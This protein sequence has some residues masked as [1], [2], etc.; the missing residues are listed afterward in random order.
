M[1]NQKV[2]QENP[3]PVIDEGWW[4][5]VLAEESRVFPRS[6]GNYRSEGNNGAKPAQNRGAHEAKQ[7][8]PSLSSAVK[9][10]VAD[11]KRLKDLYMQDQI[12][13]LV[14][15]GFN[16]GGLLVEGSGLYGFVPF[17][18][19]VELAGK[20]DNYDRDHALEADVG[21]A[22]HLKVIECGPEGGR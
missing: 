12:I 20:T 9:E 18:H 5:S 16:H 15:T 11:W 4:A 17:S 6:A 21:R 10:P 19:L 1:A 3:M 8:A 7:S 22:L 2:R 13:D 14:V